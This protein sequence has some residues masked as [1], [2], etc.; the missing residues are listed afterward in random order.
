[1]VLSSGGVKCVAT[2]YVQKYSKQ[3]YM[4]YCIGEFIKNICNIFL[5]E[6]ISLLFA[7]ETEQYSNSIN[8]IFP[9]AIPGL[10]GG[11][12]GFGKMLFKFC[13]IDGHHLMFS[14][15]HSVMLLEERDV[16]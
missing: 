4:A 16:L 5:T 3:I 2:H 14:I 10:L 12:C 13:S 9:F 15:F 1:M 8:D 7:T 11:Q 6:E